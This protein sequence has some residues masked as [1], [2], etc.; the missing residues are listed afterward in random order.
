[1]SNNYEF[2]PEDEY[3]SLKSETP[4]GYNSGSSIYGS[5]YGTPTSGDDDGY[6]PDSSPEY[7]AE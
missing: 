1:M 6:E 3:T 4:Y 2:G 7:E 5:T